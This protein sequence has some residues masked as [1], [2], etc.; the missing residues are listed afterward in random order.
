MTVKVTDI[1]GAAVVALLFLGVIFFFVAGQRK[2]EEKLGKESEKLKTKGFEITGR[3]VNVQTNLDLSPEEII[4]RA[5]HQAQVVK[6]QIHTNP[7]LV[8]F[9]QKKFP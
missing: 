5:S 3:G 8:S 6:R 7:N 2:V 4:Q 1:I 9:G